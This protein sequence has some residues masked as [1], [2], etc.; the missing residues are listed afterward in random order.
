[1]QEINKPSIPSI[2]LKKFIIAAPKIIIIGIYKTK[3]VKLNDSNSGILNIKNVQVKICIPNLSS[4]EILNLSSINPTMANGKESKGIKNPFKEEKIELI[5]AKIIPPP[6][7][8][9]S[10]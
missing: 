1:M 7:G 9:D 6:V 5:E 2:K 3:E 4:D 10:L 8:L